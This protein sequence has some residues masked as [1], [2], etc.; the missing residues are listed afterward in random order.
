M[1]VLQ[2]LALTY[3]HHQSYLR[4]K[5]KI[6]SVPKSIIVILHTFIDTFVAFS[7]TSIKNQKM[8]IVDLNILITQ[9]LVQIL[10]FDEKKWVGEKR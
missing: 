9:K 10:Y 1:K 5:A 6:L 8:T 7:G 3:C 4:E 2:L